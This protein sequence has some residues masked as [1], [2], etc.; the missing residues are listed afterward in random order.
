MASLS[1]IRRIFNRDFTKL[2]I[3]QLISNFGDNFFYMGLMATIL[4]VLDLDAKYLGF[5]MVMIAVPTLIFGPIAGSYVDRWN[6]KHVM[7]VADVL[8]GFI[9]LSL[10]FYHELWYIYGSVFMLATVSRFFYPAQSAIIPDIVDEDVLMSANSFSQTTYMLATIL[11]PAMGAALIGMFGLR[12]V[13]LFDGI[14]FFV[15]S[16]CIMWMSFSGEVKRT[17]EKKEVWHETAEGIKFSFRHPVIKGVMLYIFIL[18]LFFGGFGPLYMVFIRDVLHMNLFQM[19]VL[20]GL[21]GVGSLIGSITIGVMGSAFSKKSMVFGA[22]MTLAGM[23]VLLVLFP[24]SWVAFQTLSFFGIA[25]VFFNTPVTTLLQE[26]APDEIRGRVFGAFGAIMQ[27]A[28]LLSM[29]VETVLADAVGVSSVMLAVG[30]L[31]LL[32]G[33][34]FFSFKKNRAVFEQQGLNGENNPAS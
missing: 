15:S 22:N 17:N 5:L 10:V 3:G 28:T 21:Q 19:G 23:V 31:G 25:M 33:L 1:N 20:E 16:M 18:I 9:V 11:G 12:S 26:S 8:R 32:F 29:G 6:R 4:Y 13:F 7:A 27:I 14:S 24:Y 2:W 30:I 34:S